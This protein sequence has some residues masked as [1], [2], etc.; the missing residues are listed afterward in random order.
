MPDRF[1]QWLRDWGTP[2]VVIAAATFL[3]NHLDA[4]ENDLRA[5]IINRTE[6][7]HADIRQIQNDIRIIKA[8]LNAT[9]ADLNATTAALN[10]RIDDSNKRIDD[11]NKRIDATN[12]R[13]DLAN[14][15]M[16]E[17]QG[18]VTTDDPSDSSTPNSGTDG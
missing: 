10:A 9:R 1:R 4:V 18:W 3:W 16:D 14:R 7:L 11:S 17:A 5:E 6:P 15:R 8:D 12:R 13:I 2:A